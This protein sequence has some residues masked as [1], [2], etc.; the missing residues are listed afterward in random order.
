MKSLLLMPALL[1]FAAQAAPVTYE[2]D[3]T[4]T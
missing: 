2:I 1:A 4:H 3:P